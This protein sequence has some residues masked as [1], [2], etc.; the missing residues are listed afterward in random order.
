ML[1]ESCPL[2]PALAPDADGEILACDTTLALTGVEVFD[3]WRPAAENYLSRITR[4][5]LI[6]LG[7]E[8]FGKTWGPRWATARKGDLVKELASAFADPKKYAANNKD[9]EQTLRTWLP[10]GM[11]FTLPVSKPARTKRAA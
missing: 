9:V 6:A 4:D 1:S 7:S 5:Q 8:I 2:E 10:E 11:A 3:Y